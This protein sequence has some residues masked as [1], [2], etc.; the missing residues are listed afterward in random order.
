MFRTTFSLF[1]F[2]VFVSKKNQETQILKCFLNQRVK[3]KLWNLF[4]T[5]ESRKRFFETTFMIHWLESTI[6]ETA[7]LIL[8]F[9]SAN[10]ALFY[11]EQFWVKAFGQ[12]KLELKTH[13][14][15]CQHEYW[16]H[17]PWLTDCF[18]SVNQ[19]K[20]LLVLRFEP[21][22]QRSCFKEPV[23]DSLART[24][25]SKK[26]FLIRWFETTFQGLCFWFYRP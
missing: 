8:W 15:S 3:K 22:N 5:K 6:L 12:R 20:S 14:D 4:R 9:E 26:H 16:S 25:I 19:N 23:F 10:R 2:V 24:V 21:E 18:E 13:R 1:Y 7:F 17:S 11:T